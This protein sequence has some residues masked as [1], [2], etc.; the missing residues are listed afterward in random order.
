MAI[1]WNTQ[2]FDELIAPECSTFTEADIPNLQDKYE[3]RRYWVTHLFLNSALQGR[4]KAPIN[5]YVTAYLRRAEGAFIMHDLARK[6]TI[7]LL[8]QRQITPSHY[9][10]ALLHWE[11]F[12]GQAAQAQNIFARLTKSM[13]GDDHF[14]LYEPN[15]GSVNQRLHSIYNSLKHAEKRINAGQMP[16][17]SVSPVWMVNEGLRSTDAHLTWKET[18]EELDSLA[19]WADGFQSP[20]E[21]AS[22]LAARVGEQAPGAS[23]E[24]TPTAD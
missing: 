8:A 9:T 17:N 19:E 2:L 15:A 23:S 10:R 24:G 1:S 16:P 4:Y 22:W 18:G 14:R 20:S 3:N 21:L 6:A 13:A 5:S 7:E 11:N 12:L